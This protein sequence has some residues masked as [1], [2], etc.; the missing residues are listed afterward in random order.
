MVVFP[1]LRGEL[2][3]IL[4][5]PS[6]LFR[7]GDRWLGLRKVDYSVEC[8]CSQADGMRGPSPTC[9]RCMGLGHPFADELVKGYLWR[10]FFTGTEFPAEPGIISTQG[11]NLIVRYSDVVNKFDWVLLLD[12]N[13]ETGEPRQPFNIRQSFVVVDSLGLRG[14]N[15]RVEYWRCVLQERNISDGRPGQVGTKYAYKSNVE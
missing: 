1:D 2:R 7:Y 13:H 4:E 5:D 9:T 3:K 14:Q 15:G 11:R 6:N 8:L 10:S 12:L